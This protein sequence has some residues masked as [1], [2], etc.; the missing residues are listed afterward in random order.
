MNAGEQWD[1]RL[2]TKEIWRLKVVEALRRYRVV[3]TQYSAVLARHPTEGVSATSS[4]E[5]LLRARMAKATAQAECLRVL[6]I[7][8]DL[9][10][11]GTIPDQKRYAKATN[12]RGG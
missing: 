3:A 8:T 1:Q 6:R 9:M 2:D 11:T 7:F 10:L 5:A 4:N 12:S